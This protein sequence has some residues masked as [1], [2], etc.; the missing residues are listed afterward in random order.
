MSYTLEQK[1]A[2]VDRMELWWRF[3]GSESSY[4]DQWTKVSTD[5]I[6][7]EIC[8]LPTIGAEYFIGPTPP[9]VL[10]ELEGELLEALNELLIDMRLAQTNMRA[11]AKRDPAWEGCAEAIQPRVDA[12]IAAIKKAESTPCRSNPAASRRSKP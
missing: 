3:P 11:A 5:I 1:Q 7:V 2:A 8:D 12:A 4:S 9:R 10:S 6:D